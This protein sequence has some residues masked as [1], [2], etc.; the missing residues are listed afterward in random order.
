MGG[1][2]PLKQVF[3]L[4]EVWV[5]GKELNA[6]FFTIVQVNSL[7]LFTIYDT[8]TYIV[9]IFGH[10]LTKIGSYLFGHVN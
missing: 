9:K 10:V 8:I 5:S 1:Q 7:L 4:Q 6:A 2:K 3:E